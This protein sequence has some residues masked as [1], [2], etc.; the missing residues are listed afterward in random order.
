MFNSLSLVLILQLVS[1]NGHV[2]TNFLLSIFLSS[3]FFWVTKYI[4]TPK[5][6]WDYIFVFITIEE[7]RDV[8]EWLLM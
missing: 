2:V 7:T 3:M 1:L 6:K 4:K 8:E 5:Q